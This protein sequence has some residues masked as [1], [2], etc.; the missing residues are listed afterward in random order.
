MAP[1]PHDLEKWVRGCSMSLNMAPFDRPYDFL[2]VGHC[3]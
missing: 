1:R 2:L 3:K